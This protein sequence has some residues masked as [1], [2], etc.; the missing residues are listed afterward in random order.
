MIERTTRPDALHAVICLPLLGGPVFPGRA[1]TSLASLSW[2]PGQ[3][4]F[5]P[6]GS[7]GAGA[8]F[9]RRCA[10]PLTSP[11]SPRGHGF[12]PWPPPKGIAPS[13]F[14]REEPMPSTTRLPLPGL[15]SPAGAPPFFGDRAAARGARATRGLLPRMAG[16]RFGRSLGDA[17]A[18]GDGREGRVLSRSRRAPSGSGRV[19]R[20]LAACDPGRSEGAF[21]RAA[22]ASG[23]AFLERCRRRGVSRT[24]MR[25]VYG[26]AAG[27]RG[28][29]GDPACMRSENRRWRP[30]FHLE[31]FPI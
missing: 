23:R 25:I 22:A 29:S 26:R 16:V 8:P 18:L 30:C 2:D 1:P 20:D 9:G 5:P 4:G 10:P 12:P 28:P 7:T 27:L 24:G 13:Y 31:R 14:G 11:P 3:P 21:R 6:K 17:R 19:L 15:R